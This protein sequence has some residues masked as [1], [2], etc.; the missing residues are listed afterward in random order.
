MPGVWVNPRATNRALYFPTFPSSPSVW[1]KCHFLWWCPVLI[2]ASP[3]PR[4]HRC[5][6]VGIRQGVC[7]TS[8]KAAWNQNIT[9]KWQVLQF[10]PS[11]KSRGALRVLPEHM[12]VVCCTAVVLSVT[13]GVPSFGLMFSSDSPWN[14]WGIV[15]VASHRSFISNFRSST[16][17]WDASSSSLISCVTAEPRWYRN[18]SSLKFTFRDSQTFGALDSDSSVAATTYA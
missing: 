11:E 5:F 2:M 6:P 1:E 16:S 17:D 8:W 10:L 4:H 18:S 15:D 13:L 12:V 7:W 14:E 3:A 9:V